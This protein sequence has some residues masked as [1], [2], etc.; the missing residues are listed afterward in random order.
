[1]YVDVQVYMAPVLTFAQE[2]IAAKAYILS[3]SYKLQAPTVK[4]T[5]LTVL[6]IL[7]AQDS[8]CMACSFINMFFEG[9]CQEL[10]G[11]NAACSKETHTLGL[12]SDVNTKIGFKRVEQNLCSKFST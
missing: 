4:T 6:A 1:M 3:P 12:A 5:A 8:S 11:E 7:A 2:C 9:F 10:R